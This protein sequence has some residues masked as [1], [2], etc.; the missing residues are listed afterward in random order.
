MTATSAGN[1][2][3]L[4]LLLSRLTFFFP[5]PSVFN[6]DNHTDHDANMHRVNRNNLNDN[7][8]A[9]NAREPYTI[10][11]GYKVPHVALEPH[12]RTM[13]ADR[14]P[15]MPFAGGRPR[16]M[17]YIVSFKCSRVGV[18]YLL[19]NTGLQ[20]SEGD[21]VIV[22][23]DR[24]QDL[25]VVQHA[26]ITQEEARTLLAKYG[27]EQY[28]WLMMFSQNNQAGA[29]N[30]NAAVYGEA[31]GA[32]AGNPNQPSTRP[33]RDAFQNLKPKAIKRMAAPHEIRMLMD[34]EGN[35]AKAKR[36]CQQKV[37]QHHLDM[38][39]LEAEFQWYVQN[40]HSNAMPSNT[41]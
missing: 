40:S 35:E 22:E 16:K 7:G 41:Y 29:V 39:I 34:K 15:T 21:M 5:S 17:L 24:G 26:C 25:G 33:P 10:P 1:I 36:A 31:N 11:E 18:F 23:A 9:T 13:N 38:E 20:V 32:G 12:E 27:E 28:K 37:Y 14:A 3:A 2:S 19:D 30:P 8:A 6:L 4:I